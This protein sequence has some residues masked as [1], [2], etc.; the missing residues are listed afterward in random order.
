[1][2][3]AFEP[4]HF[5]YLRPLPHGQGSFRPSLVLLLRLLFC[6]LDIRNQVGKF[7]RRELWRPVVS[8]SSGF[9]HRLSESSSSCT[10]TPGDSTL[11]A[12]SPVAPL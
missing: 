12:G 7:P 3:G 4:W 9:L 2:R 6:L 1:M 11:F 5:L 8:A 10:S